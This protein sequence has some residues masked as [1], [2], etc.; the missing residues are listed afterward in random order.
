MG[1]CRFCNSMA[2]GS[3][4][5]SPHKKHEHDN[6]EKKCVFCG[7]AAYGSCP[8]SPVKK[9]RHGSGANKCVWCGSTATG[10]GCAHGPSRVHEK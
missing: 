9:H 6:D 5:L 7:S 1:R 2:Y 10:R 4:T 8:Q 3:C